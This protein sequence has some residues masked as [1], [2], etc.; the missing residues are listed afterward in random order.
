MYKKL[1]YSYVYH[2]SSIVFDNVCDACTDNTWRIRQ[3][4][5]CLILTFKQ[6]LFRRYVFGRYVFPKSYEH[7]EKNLAKSYFSS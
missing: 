6:S 5:L 3:L 7:N 1:Q 2:N 4:K